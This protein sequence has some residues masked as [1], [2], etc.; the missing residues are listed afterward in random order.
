MLFVAHTQI[1]PSAHSID[2]LGNDPRRRTQALDASVLEHKGVAGTFRHPFLV[3]R[4]LG[5]QMARPFLD[6]GLETKGAEAREA[7]ATVITDTLR[8]IAYERRPDGSVLRL[9]ILGESASAEAA[10]DQTAAS[11]EATAA[12]LEEMSASLA[13]ADASM[14]SVAATAA[15][16]GTE[17]DASLEG[18]STRAAASMPPCSTPMRPWRPG[19]PRC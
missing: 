2:R 14:D 9:I 15:A 5:G 19:V 16:S 13:G 1:H 6:P 18:A 4:D 10:L 3:P 8:F 12:E 11:A 7:I 17:V